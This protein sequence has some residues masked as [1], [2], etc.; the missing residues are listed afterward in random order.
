MFIKDFITC[1]ILIISNSTCFSQPDS[2]AKIVVLGVTHSA[3]LVNSNFRPAALRA[4]IKKLNPK[5]ICIERTADEF[6][7]ND[8]YEFTYEQQFCVIPYAKENSIPLYPFDWMPS[9]KDFSLV[10]GDSDLE[11]PQ[12]TRPKTGI[13]GFIFFGDSIS[14]KGD[15]FY[16]DDPAYQKEYNRGSRK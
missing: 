8:F 15:L 10:F 11:L 16:A 14:L 12:F 9:P 2:K 4:F 3:Q 1:F 6:A 7:K 5:A 13:K